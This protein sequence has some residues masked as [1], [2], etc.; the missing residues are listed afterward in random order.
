MANHMR[1]TTLEGQQDSAY[2]PESNRKS[3]LVS[4]NN[5]DILKMNFRFR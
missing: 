1:R 2:D 3:P 5:I 4:S